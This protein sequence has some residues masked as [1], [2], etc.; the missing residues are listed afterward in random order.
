MAKTYLLYEIMSVISK[1]YLRPFL[2]ATIIRSGGLMHPQPIDEFVKACGTQE[3]AALAL[4]ISRS[5]IATWL[6]RGNDIYIV[7]G[8][9]GALTW[10]QIRRAS[11]K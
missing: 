3:K 1:R 7:P 6:F 11:A 4:G 5:T 10:Y 9:D 8:P 2:N